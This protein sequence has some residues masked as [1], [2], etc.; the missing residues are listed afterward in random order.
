M[1]NKFSNYNEIVH[2]AA[3]SLRKNGVFVLEDF[4]SEDI[5]DSISQKVINLLD[6]DI[7]KTI[8]KEYKDYIVHAKDKN[9]GGHHLDEQSKPVINIRGNSG[10]DTDFCDIFNPEL[11]F[12]EINLDELKI[13]DFFKGIISKFEF[14]DDKGRNILYPTPYCNIYYTNGITDTRGWH[15]DAPMVKF[16]VYL[17][18]VNE[19]EYGPYCY[20]PK[21]HLGD[22]NT[23]KLEDY[24]HNPKDRLKLLAKWLKDYS[25]GYFDPYTEGVLEAQLR[26]N[27]DET[28]QKI[29]DYLEEILAMDDEQIKNELK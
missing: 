18:D 16:F 8:T 23:K 24:E 13:N 4:I 2:M 27:K 15:K 22:Y 1:D 3:A 7:D 12:K 11:L 29:G 25:D 10:W 26:Q 28:I 5:C 20:L 9:E 17:T 21:S 19:E 14:V 6:N